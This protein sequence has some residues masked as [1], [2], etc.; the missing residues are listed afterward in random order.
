VGR[1]QPVTRGRCAALLALS[2]AFLPGLARADALTVDE[3]VR[4]ALARAPSARAAASELDAAQQRLRAA[5]AAYVPRLLGEAEYGRS[6][7]YDETVT[8]G[9]STA[10]RVMLQ[11][12]LL[13]GGRRDAKFEAARARL[14]SAAAV[15][16]QRRADVAFAVRSAYF[17]A[18]AAQD[19][20]HVRAAAVDET[21]ADVRVLE[22]LEERGLAQ[23]NDVL[24]ARLAVEA[25]RSAGRAAVA[26]L[27]TALGELSTLTAA[28]VA[29]GDLIDP[30][31]SAIVEPTDGA[32]EASPLMVDA[33]AAV[34]AARRDADA[35]RSERREQVTFTADGGFLGVNPDNTFQKFG[36]A[37][38][39]LGFSVPLF[40]GGVLAAR[41]AEAEAAARAAAANGRET[42][43]TI[44]LALSRGAVEAR[45]ARAEL[46]AWKRAVPESEEAFQL[47]RARYV[48][49]G[50]V[51][52]LEVLDA[53][54]QSIDA[55][56]NVVQARLAYRLA[57]AEQDHVLGRGAE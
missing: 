44:A 11:A 15:E 53:L 20:S 57:V 35:A 14:Q 6:G 32:I 4:L 21:T 48:G 28:E 26:A 1:R 3:C 42:R 23:H 49:G 25:A 18:L 2:I 12:P 29:A 19:E 52:L 22:K 7:G 39:L 47:I 5:R 31:P 37:E 50:D 38:F 45:R 16:R 56:H 13:D 17:S 40:D 27:D 9:G 43:Q 41:V 55:R 34:E 54:N 8:N 33:R 51:R 10:A 46:E 36:G 30:G 24:R